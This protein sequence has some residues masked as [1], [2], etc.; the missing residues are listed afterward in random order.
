[1]SKR[2]PLW[3]DTDT[4]VD[5][6]AALLVACRE[7]GLELRGVSAVAGNVELF[8]TFE[9]AR[10]VLALAGRADVPVYPGASRPLARELHTAPYVHGEDGLGGAPL[11]PSPAPEQ[12]LPAWD[13]LYAEAVAQKGALEVAAVGP[14]TNLAIA[15]GK[16]PRLKTLLR[17]VLIMGG[18]AKGGNVTPAAEFNIYADPHAAQ[19]VFR[20]GIPLVMCGLDVTMSAYLTPEEVAAVGAH[21]TPACRFFEQSTRLAMAVCERYSGAGLCLH[22]VCPVL[23]VTQPQ[24]FGGQEAGVFVETRGR[25]TLGKTVTDLWS[26]RGFEHKNAFVVLTVDRPAFVARV[27]AALESI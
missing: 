21:G 16:Y 20:A 5:D 10:R 24:L 13:A 23:Y 1:M 6:A 18:A 4:G 19:A 11:P 14:L 7:E 17:R 22:D 12:T 25:I 15:L 26:D 8:H 2:I 9:N 3:I 27:R